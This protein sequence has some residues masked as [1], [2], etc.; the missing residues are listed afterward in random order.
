MKPERRY[1]VAFDPG[2]TTGVAWLDGDVFHSAQFEEH[3]FYEWVDDLCFTMKH[4]Q[5]EQFVINSGTVKKTIVYDSLYL[6]GY[7]RYCA[8]RCD[9][10]TSFSKPAEVMATFPDHALKRAGMHF[11]GHGHA[12]D[13]ARH[14]ARYMVTH[15]LISG[16]A[17]LPK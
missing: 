12:N 2:V 3:P 9:F 11:P 4:A 14:L 6:I 10:T 17:F 1:I 8:W 7:L 5:I 16:S 15:G 13:A